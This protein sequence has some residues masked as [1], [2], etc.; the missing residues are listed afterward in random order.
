MMIFMLPLWFI[1]NQL[2]LTDVFRTVADKNLLD[3][4]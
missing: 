3:I 1:I 4:L 2:W